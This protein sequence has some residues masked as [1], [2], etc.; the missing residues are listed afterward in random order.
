MS[1]MEHVVTWRKDP[2]VR[3]QQKLV[4]VTCGDIRRIE[5]QLIRSLLYGRDLTDDELKLCAYILKKGQESELEES[6]ELFERASHG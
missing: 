4:P 2:A 6:P 3:G 1:R 5:E